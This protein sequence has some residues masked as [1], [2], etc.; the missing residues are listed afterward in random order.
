MNP[1]ALSIFIFVLAFVVAIVALGMLTISNRL[2]KQSGLPEWEIIYEDASGL[3]RNPL[4]SRRLGLAGK[5]DYLLKNKDGSL[6]PVEVKSGFAP[7]GHQPHDS[8]LLQLAAYFF[9]IEDVLKC[10]TQYGLIRY[11]NRTL[12]IPNSEEL[13]R[14]LMDTIAQMRTLQA[15]GEPHRNH[16][17]AQRCSRCSMAHACDERIV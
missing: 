4:F 13:R 2:K 7:S 9:L 17:Q 1:S 14:K 16:N 5:P 6:I 10:Q 12:Q 8:H 15:R 11:R 3:A